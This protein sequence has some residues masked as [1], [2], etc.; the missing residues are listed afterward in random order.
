[1]GIFII[2]NQIKKINWGELPADYINSLRDIHN[3]EGVFKSL[4]QQEFLNEMSTWYTRIKAIISNPFD[5]KYAPSSGIR[6]R[7]STVRI[8]IGDLEDLFIAYERM[9]NDLRKIYI[10][11]DLRSEP[12]VINMPNS[13][14]KEQF[15]KNNPQALF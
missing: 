3:H 4:Y 2:L 14:E 6:N 11:T 12:T 15:I 8:M 5:Q 9:D 7:T 1:M 10:D 13:I